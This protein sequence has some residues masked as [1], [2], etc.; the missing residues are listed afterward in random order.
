MQGIYIYYIFIFTS[1]KY[2]Y[3]L[4]VRTQIKIAL[5]LASSDIGTQTAQPYSVGYASG[6]ARWRVHD[7]SSAGNFGW[8]HQFSFYAF[9]SEQ[10]KIPPGTKQYSVGYKTGLPEGWRYKLSKG[11]KVGGRWVHQFTFRA[12]S[13]AGKPGTQPYS[14]GYVNDRWGR[15]FKVKKGTN[16]GGGGW[17]HQFTFWAFPSSITLQWRT[18]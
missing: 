5:F 6:P 8:T 4:T 13:S 1:I 9:P 14:V 17:V 12:Y 3:N 11:R 10:G 2:N 7:S 18:E 16:A 15:R